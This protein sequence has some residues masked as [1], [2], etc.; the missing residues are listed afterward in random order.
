MPSWL[1]DVALVVISFLA[2][3]LLL[4]TARRIAATGRLTAGALRKLVHIAAGTWTLFA[5][6]AFRHLGWA[7]VPPVAFVAWNASAKARRW[8][9]P[10][11]DDDLHTRGLWTF[12]AGV[13][14]A[15]ALFWEPAG[16]HAILAGCAALAFA[17]PAAAMAG[18]RLGQRRFAP[19]GHG[20]TLEG[21]LAFFLV[22]AVSTGIIASGGGPVYALRLAVGC[23]AVGAVAEALSPS[24]WDNLAVP[25]AVAWAYRTLA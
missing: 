24:G 14:L 23:A 6:L 15:Y 7:L 2:L 4:W 3:G 22:A 19:F 9:P 11:A 5:T 16:R 20:R 17:D 12:P 10:L 25:V 18:A 8:M 21:T 13:A 1:P